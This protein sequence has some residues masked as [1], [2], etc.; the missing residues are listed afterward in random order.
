[1]KKTSNTESTN[2][3]SNNDGIEKDDIALPSSPM[4]IKLITGE[5]LIVSS[6]ITD[7]STGQ[8]MVTYP[9]A[10]MRTIMNGTTNLYLSKWMSYA[11]SYLFII[12]RH[13]V[14]T[15]NI[16]N[17]EILSYYHIC[18]AEEYEDDFEEQ[19]N[20]KQVSNAYH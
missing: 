13:S 20:I 17:K 7:P 15:I 2:T 16:P 10:V 4:V 14:V 19:S 8:I 18:L 11:A 5:E 12:S 9:Y 1:M 3:T 6:M